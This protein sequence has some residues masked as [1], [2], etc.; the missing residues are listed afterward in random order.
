MN[1]PSALVAGAFVLLVVA[2]AILFVTATSRAGRR[3]SEPKERTRRYA[4]T[5]AVTVTAVLGI[6]ATLASRGVL[7]NFGSVPP[8]ILRVLVPTVILT[9]TLALSPFGT[10]LVRG[11]PITALVGFQSFRII[12][13]LILFALH[14][15]GFI[16]VQM[17]F[18]GLNFDVVTGLTAIPIAWLAARD[19]L[20]RAA[21][22]AW[23][24]GGLVLLIIIATIANLSMPTPFRAF[25]DTPPV[26]VIAEFPFV[27]LPVI[28]VQ[29]ALFGHV[30]V[31]R[32]LRLAH[33]VNAYAVSVPIGPATNK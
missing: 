9:L 12:V 11:I 33:G 31:F 4:L 29:A 6:S 19:R 3:L 13:E 15:Q 2:I 22:L 25:T 17:T 32:W 23:N 1:T 16:P 7:R 27:W 18:E 26:T 24:I 10:R 30:L 14:R 20:P 8:M 5:A 21:L 28:L